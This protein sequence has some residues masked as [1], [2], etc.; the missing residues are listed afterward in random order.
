[1]KHLLFFYGIVFLPFVSLAQ[2]PNGYTIRGRLTGLDEGEKVLMTLGDANGYD[3]NKRVVCDSAFVRNGE[4]SLQGVVPDG[5]RMYWMDFEKHMNKTMY[6]LIDKGEN[7]TISGDVDIE[8][9]PH[10]YIQGHVKID[11]SKANKTFQ[12]ME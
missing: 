10:L 11:G 8:K 7:I 5:P 3:R 1:M 2:S 4:F 6:L 9:I 12:Y